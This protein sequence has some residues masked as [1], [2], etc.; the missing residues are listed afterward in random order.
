VQRGTA[1]PIMRGEGVVA[2]ALFAGVN[3]HASRFA[4]HAASWSAKAGHAAR[5]V[6][7]LISAAAV[8]ILSP[9]SLPQLFFAPCEPAPRACGRDSDCGN[10]RSGAWP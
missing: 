4:G 10:G 1:V 8:G 2:E 7:A 6:N 3:R 9:A 5:L